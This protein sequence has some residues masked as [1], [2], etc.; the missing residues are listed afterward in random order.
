MKECLFFCLLT[1]VAISGICSTKSANANSLEG[2]LEKTEV[3]GSLRS[4]YTNKYYLQ[5]NLPNKNI[6][7]LNGQ[8]NALSGE[9]YP[10][11]KIGTSM[12]FATSIKTD[13]TSHSN[14]FNDVTLNQVYIQ[15]KDKYILFKAGNQIIDTP[16]LLPSNTEITPT[17]YLSLYG[18]YTPNKDL[19]F[20]ALQVFRFND[21]ASDNFSNINLY[22][23]DSMDFM[24][25]MDNRDITNRKVSA[26]GAQYTYSNINMQTWYYHFHDLAN[27][28]YAD[29][30]YETKTDLKAQIG[31]QVVR[32]WG[33]GN[34][35]S[36]AYSSGTPNA[37]GVGVMV[38]AKKENLQLSLGY[39]YI[40]T[41][42]N[43]FH[44][45]NVLSPY[46]AGGDPLYTTSTLAGLIEKAPGHAVKVTAN[47]YTLEN[48]LQISGSYAKYFTAPLLSNSA[49]FDVDTKY[50]FSGPLQGLS[51]RHC[52]A[53]TTGGSSSSLIYNRLTLQYNF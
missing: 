27:L 20:T 49:E 51:I 14:N 36:S 46:T 24:E 28:V 21:K 42:K 12:Y 52:L 39:N 41:N 43:A 40:P 18:N 50:L 7:S 29:I 9:F 44:Q 8:I 23:T 13:K 53:I 19:K 47:F 10:G 17:S 48:K 3:S 11:W 30:N 35:L 37:L 32:E 25:K 1:L 31:L 34:N 4:Y 2:V 15:Y 22:N 26:L 16:W 45:G 6:I 5:P 38:G 33:D